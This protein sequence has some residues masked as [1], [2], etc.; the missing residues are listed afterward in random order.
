MPEPLFLTDLWYFAMAGRHL[1]AGRTVAKTIAGEPF[2]IGRDTAGKVFALRDL[3]PHRGMPL[4]F[5]RFDGREVE[6]CYHGWRFDTTGTCTAIPALSETS[7]LDCRRIRVRRYP[8]R[9]HQGVVWLFL[10]EDRDDLPPVPEVPDIGDRVPNLA[11][12][13]DLPCNADHGIV[14][15]IDPAHGPYVHRSWWWRSGKKFRE[16][17]KAFA[18][19]P[20]GFTMVKHRPSSNSPAYRL[21][22]GKGEVTTEIDFRLPGIR[23]EIV[24][25]GE[26]RFCGLTAVTPI[27]ENTS[28]FHHVI[29]WTSPRVSL[30]KPFLAVFMKRFLAQDGVAFRKQGVGLAHSPP[31]M[32]VEDPDRQAR[33]YFA[34]KKEFTAAK[35]EGRPVR[36]PVDETV[37]H[38]RS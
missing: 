38:W 6:C 16:K 7:T 3:C 36:N 30:A 21:L 35:K 12:V 18:P 15:L 19:N 37:L 32:L 29:Y 9:E 10:G 27:T 5:G 34:L 26:H 4:S 17:A 31:L 33:W 13:V 2:L 24:R 11:H 22:G 8:C 14:G 28:A 25:V 1:K 23:T 20:L